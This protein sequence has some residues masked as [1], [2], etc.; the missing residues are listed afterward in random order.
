[1]GAE[2]RVVRCERKRDQL[3]V[4][5]VC[6]IARNTF[7]EVSNCGSKGMRFDPRSEEMNG[8]TFWAL[9]IK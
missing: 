7:I 1:V 5:E 9:K 4:S 6:T 8:K 3:D 2:R